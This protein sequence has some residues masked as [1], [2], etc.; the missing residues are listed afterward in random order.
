[1]GRGGGRGAPPNIIQKLKNVLGIS[2]SAS[3][4]KVRKQFHSFLEMPVPATPHTVV[5]WAFLG[6]E[7]QWT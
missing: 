2:V 1:M 7:T 5:G 3:L 4:Q 6:N